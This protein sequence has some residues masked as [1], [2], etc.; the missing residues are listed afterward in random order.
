MEGDLVE[1]FGWAGLERFGW[2]GLEGFALERGSLPKETAAFF[3]RQAK[4]SLCGGCP[5]GPH[6]LGFFCGIFVE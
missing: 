1:G 2:A 6:S 5:S 4:A 3:S